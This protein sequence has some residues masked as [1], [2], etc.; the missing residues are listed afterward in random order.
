MTPLQDDPMAA[1]REV[2]AVT[3]E[4]AAYWDK[5]KPLNP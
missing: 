5:N 2:Q 1:V 3:N 4:Y